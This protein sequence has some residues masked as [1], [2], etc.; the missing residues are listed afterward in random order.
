L[1]LLTNPPTRRPM[2]KAHG[3]VR[4]LKIRRRTE[5]LG[6]DGKATGSA[7][8]PP[9]S[10]A[11]TVPGAHKLPR[12][13]GG[14]PP[15]LPVAPGLLRAYENP[16]PECADRSNRGPIVP[17][18][19]QASS[20]WGRPRSR[21]VRA[22]GT[23]MAPAWEE[24]ARK[25]SSGA[26]TRAS[27]PTGHGRAGACPVTLTRCLRRRYVPRVRPRRRMRARVPH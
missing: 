25:G 20:A 11:P 13:Q 27:S 22:A 16:Q 21:R 1:M 14:G 12:G 18:I 2:R 24:A 3:R 19:T 7:G 9:A 26:A 4:T 5:G 10:V 8:G 15:A 6:V 17:T 23:R